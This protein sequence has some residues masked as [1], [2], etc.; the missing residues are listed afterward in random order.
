M[1]AMSYLDGHIY[2]MAGASKQHNRIA[3]N[4]INRLNRQQRQK[5]QIFFQI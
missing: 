2:L 5:L 4:F 3:R 1:N